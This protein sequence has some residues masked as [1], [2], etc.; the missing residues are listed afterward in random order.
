MAMPARSVTQNVRACAAATTQSSFA[1][2]ATPG[3]PV[4]SAHTKPIK[5]PDSDDATLA[6]AAGNFHSISAARSV[7]D[8]TCDVTEGEH[9]GCC[10]NADIFGHAAGHDLSCAPLRDLLR[11]QDGLCTTERAHPLIPIYDVSH[12][13]VT[14]DALV[15]SDVQCINQMRQ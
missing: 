10:H 4:H 9:A 11:C 15:I 1:F 2:G 12:S 14:K 13:C 6:K 3:T 5:K 7:I 8:S